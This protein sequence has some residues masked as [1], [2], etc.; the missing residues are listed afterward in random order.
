MPPDRAWRE[1]PLADTQ[2][3]ERA[4]EAERAHLDALAKRLCANSGI[5]V[6]TVLLEGTITDTVADLIAAQVRE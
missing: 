4:C 3:G 2:P 1:S 6:D 5:S